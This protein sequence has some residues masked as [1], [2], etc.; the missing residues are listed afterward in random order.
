MILTRWIKFPCF[1]TVKFN[2][3]IDLDCKYIFTWEIFIFIFAIWICWW[4]YYQ[5]DVSGEKYNADY[6]PRYFRF[7]CFIRGYFQRPV[8]SCTCPSASESTQKDIWNCITWPKY[9]ALIH[10]LL[11]CASCESV[12]L[13]QI[14]YSKVWIFHYIC[15]TASDLNGMDSQHSGTGT[16]DGTILE[17]KCGWT[18]Y[19]I[20]LLHDWTHGGAN[21][22]GAILQ[23]TYSDSF[24]VRTL[25]YFDSNLNETCY[26]GQSK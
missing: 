23:T 5:A 25:L 9:K 21:K 19:V 12:P 26:K 18:G 16:G 22:M 1:V 8:L 11:S 3:R 10:Q 14:Q 6:I 13:H 20:C 17:P 7:W 2:R 15:F 4:S 24:R